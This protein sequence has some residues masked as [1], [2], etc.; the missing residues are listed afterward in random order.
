[1]RKLILLVVVVAVIAAGWFLYFNNDDT[2]TLVSLSEAEYTDIQNTLE[3]SGEVMTQ[4]MYSVMSETGGTITN[5]YVSEG[6][7]VSAGDALFDL[8]TTDIE[9][10][11]REAE[12]NYEILSESA[13]Q[14]VMAQ[15]D[16]LESAA[17][18]ELQEEKAK[19][20]LALSQTTGYDYESFNESFS[21]DLN[22]SAAAMAA[23]L[24]GMSLD[25]IY[26][27]S[28]TYVS[29]MAFESEL[30][31][32]ELAIQRL[33]AQIEEMSYESLI[34]GTVIAVNVNNGEVLSPGIS[35]MVIADDENTLICG[36]VYE[37]DIAGLSIG[38]DVKIYT[39][40]GYYW[41]TLTDIGEAALEVGDISSY[42][43]MTKV[44]ITPDAAFNKMLGAVVDLEIIL[45]EKKNV[46][47]LPFDCITDESCVYVVGEDN[48]VEKRYVETGFEG[49]L[50]VEILSGLSEGEMVVLSPKNIEEGQQVSY[51]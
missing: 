32:A 21:D 37:K 25:E 7:R 14:S 4:N 5:I 17:A 36:Y 39:D 2:V 46:L 35:A 33:E 6:S 38:M 15:S 41:G 10:Q 23:A 45:S 3:F 18:E 28:D 26:G 12:L 8:D 11:L 51:D 50:N 1:M 49:A 44:E 43:T 40:E 31:L 19:I 34:D 29:D 42:E 13:T 9:S 24:E 47:A 22:E 30:E 16:A 20:A 48:I 27:S